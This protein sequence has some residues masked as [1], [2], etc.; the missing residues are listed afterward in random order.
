MKYN[1]RANGSVVAVAVSQSTE[2]KSNFCETA[3]SVTELF[4]TSESDIIISLT[5]RGLRT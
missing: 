3:A 1:P 5:S 4:L 2:N